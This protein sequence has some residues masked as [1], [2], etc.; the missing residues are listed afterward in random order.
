MRR[1]ET[2][3]RF[4]PL[5]EDILSAS[6]EQLLAEVAEDFGDARAL[7]AE[8]DSVVL[9]ETPGRD[10]GSVNENLIAP[11]S[12]AP[13]W[14][15]FSKCARILQ[16]GFSLSSDVFAANR[17]YVLTSVAFACLLLIAIVVVRSDVVLTSYVVVASDPGDMTKIPLAPAHEEPTSPA[18]AQ[19]WEAVQNTSQGG[20]MVVGQLWL[21]A[22]LQNVTQEIAGTIGL[23]RPSGVLVVNVAPKSPAARAGMRANDLVVSV[24]GQEVDDVSAFAYR[25]ATKP[26]GGQAIIVVKRDGGDV[27]LAVPLEILP[28]VARDEAVIKTRSPFL[29][30][31]IANLSPALADELR[32]DIDAKGVVVTDVENGSTAYLFGLQRGDVVLVVNNVRIQTTRD[33]VDVISRPS[34]LWRLTIQRGLQQISA[35]FTG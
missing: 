14:R 4:D 25:F 17:V 31:K 6:D 12:K 11:D 32:M 35:T 5:V 10:A 24:D 15:P 21:G 7:A 29:G 34:R 18:A 20:S 26:I 23:K 27:K 13:T 33:L 2:Q 22:R 1:G 3:Q 8:F 9:R 28:E 30:A 19:A 16:R